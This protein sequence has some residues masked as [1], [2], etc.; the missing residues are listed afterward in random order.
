MQRMVGE[1]ARFAEQDALIALR[2]EA[3]NELENCIAAIR[4]WLK[5]GQGDAGKRAEL[6]AEVEKQDTFQMKFRSEAAQKYK[7]ITANLNAMWAPLK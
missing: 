4:T 1:A 7:D 5:K 3:L 2:I 6:E